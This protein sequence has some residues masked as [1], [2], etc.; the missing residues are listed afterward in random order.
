VLIL[1]EGASLAL[2]LA[3]GF[4]GQQVQAQAVA[5]LLSGD[6][7]LVFWVGVVGCGLIVPLA[8][9]GVSLWGGADA[10]TAHWGHAFAPVALLLLVGGYCLRVSLLGA[11]LPVFTAATTVVAA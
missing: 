5:G 11:G 4:D 3:L 7:A 8:L 1:L 10:V 6:F 2:L 9:E